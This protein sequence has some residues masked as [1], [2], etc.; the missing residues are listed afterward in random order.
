M[1]ATTEMKG[2]GEEKCQGVLL[3]IP[4][5]GKGCSWHPHSPSAKRGL[6]GHSAMS[7][8]C[9]STP[10]PQPGLSLDPSHSLTPPPLPRPGIHCLIILEA[11]PQPQPL[12]SSST[13]HCIPGLP[14]QPPH[15]RPCPVFPHVASRTVL[16]ACKSGLASPPCGTSIIGP[17]SPPRKHFEATQHCQRVSII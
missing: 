9:P 15:W 16:P 12:C 2:E 1:V 10:L 13:D 4:G 7:E 17:L 11:S 3:R 5:W 14:P 8:F 6:P